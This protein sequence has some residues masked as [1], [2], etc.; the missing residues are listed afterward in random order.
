MIAST[1]L[2]A[3][4]VNGLCDEAK[5]RT[6]DLSCAV[7]PL[8]EL[9]VH[10]ALPICMDVQHLIEAEWRERCDSDW[11]EHWFLTFVQTANVMELPVG[12]APQLI[13]KLRIDFGFPADSR[14]RVLV[15]TARAAVAGFGPA[16]ALVTED[17]DFFEPGDKGCGPHRRMSYLTGTRS[18]R[19][20]AWLK[21]HQNIRVMAVAEAMQAL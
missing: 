3:N 14:D 17:L 1:V 16:C 10:S 20:K 13:K 12:T 7:M 2:D 6:H 4:V 11:I 9:L 15:L 8:F 18:G 5:D 21:Q 19:V